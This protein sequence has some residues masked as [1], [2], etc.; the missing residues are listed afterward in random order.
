MA[1]RRTVVFTIAS[2][3]YLAFV[4]TLY[5][6][7]RN[8]DQTCR[9]YC[10]LVD[11]LER[12]VALDL[13]FPLIEGR[14]IG[15]A[16]YFDMAARYDIVEMNTAV[17]PFCF[18]WLL[19]ETDADRIVYLDPDIMAMSP[20]AELEQLFDE[21]AAIVLTPHVTRP[22]N[23]GHH[24]DDHQLMKVGIYNLGFCAV[25]RSPSAAEFL[26][27]WGRHLASSCTVDTE[28]GIFVDQKYC[29]FV[30]SLFEDVVILRHPGYN[31][32]YWNLGY[33][34]VARDAAGVWRSNGMPLRFMHFSGIDPGNP[35]L[36]SKY[37]NRLTIFSVGEARSLF[38][39]YAARVS[40]HGDAMGAPPRYA[41]DVLADGTPITR[42]MRR[43]YRRLMAPGPRS[44]EEAFAADLGRYVTLAPEVVDA[45]DPPVTRLMYE[46]WLARPHLQRLM[47]IATKAGREA[48]Q[49]WFFENAVS[50]GVSGAIVDATRE[51]VRRRSVPRSQP[52]LACSVGPV[53]TV[54]RATR[55]AAT[56]RPAGAVECIDMV[57]CFSADTGPGA[58]VR[59][60]RQAAISGN[61]KVVSHDIPET[62]PGVQ[63]DPRP[64]LV[65]RDLSSD[66]IIIYV[67]ADRA[68]HVE[69]YLDPRS[70]PTRHRIGYWTWELPSFPLDWVP[71][72]AHVDEVWT[73]SHYVAGAIARRTDK[74]VHV[75][76]HPIAEPATVHSEARL[77]VGLPQGR[78]LYLVAFDLASQVRRKNP[79]GALAAF[80]RAFPPSHTGPVLVLKFHG[81]AQRD[82]QIA[83]LLRQAMSRPD[84]VVIDR[85][86]N[87]T[88]LSALRE[89]IDV[90]VSL[91]RA[92]SF[93]RWIAEAMALGKT[94]VV[95]NH[96]GPTD[97]CTT[98]NAL[99]VDHRLRD[100]GLDEFP[101]AGGQQWA[102]PDE[103][104]A[105]AALRAATDQALRARLGAAARTLMRERYSMAAVGAIMRERLYAGRAEALTLDRLVVQERG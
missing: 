86:L 4:R 28:N 41:Y 70:L 15:C 32:A 37:Q 82:R 56:R 17:K 22:L 80:M 45:P 35:T 84:V 1:S 3:N 23:D 100:V 21:G 74:P 88:D 51:V 9:F 92:E 5:A 59:A 12:E 99:L 97:F 102:E 64:S 40:H 93:G 47:A 50:L 16:S 98:E 53:G 63:L 60:H 46:A 10:F 39:E 8:S 66:C 24:P 81:M 57:G 103:E 26:S 13:P 58:N 76:P 79:A 104:S 19:R 90:F 77:R 38:E 68:A 29:D 27:W 42:E 89:A 2:T 54:R 20:F 65:R 78:L 71:A 31:V 55:W 49:E 75:V 48:L 33:R 95:T 67:N 25:R 44:R 11:E 94:C 43:V 6:S 83:D 52:G 30:P 7:L 69:A 96:S 85:A 14:Y 105:V 87:E 101:F 18:E 36:V 72:F 34:G 62:H 73:P 91:H 61:L